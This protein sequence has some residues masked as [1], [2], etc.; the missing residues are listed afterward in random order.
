[1]FLDILYS[2]SRVHGSEVQG[3]HLR[4]MREMK[5]KLGERLAR[6]WNIGKELKKS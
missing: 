1:M 2:G 5:N 3:F 4:R 6:A